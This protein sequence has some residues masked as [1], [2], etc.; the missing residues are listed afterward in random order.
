[1]VLEITHQ[2]AHV[3]SAQVDVDKVA[4]HALALQPGKSLHTL[5]VASFV[6]PQHRQWR[7]NAQVRVVKSLIA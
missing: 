1:M 6:K 3:L 4:Q 5:L 2:I 7:N